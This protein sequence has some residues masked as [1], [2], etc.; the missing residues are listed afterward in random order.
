M[1]LFPF[2]I[3]IQN[4][5]GIITGGGKHILEKIQRLKPYHPKLTIY[6]KTFLPEIEN[7]N[8]LKLVYRDMIDQ[9][10]DTNPKFVILAS[11]N[12]DENHRLSALCKEKNILVNVVDDQEYCDFI[13][14]SL[15]TH[16]HLSIGICTNGASPA[17]GV[18]YYL[19]FVLRFFF[20]IDRSC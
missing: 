15:L 11:D 3:N 16:G 20:S 10:L 14:P 2:F 19:E 12:H 5:Q 8:D 6:S 18:Q 17:T 9:D 13:F 7:D 4:E 1:T